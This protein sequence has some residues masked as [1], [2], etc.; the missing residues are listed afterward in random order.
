M[1]PVTDMWQIVLVFLV[2]MI[3]SAC[4]APVTPVGPPI[5]PNGPTYATGLVRDGKPK[6]GVMHW[7]PKHVFTAAANFS[8]ED[9]N[10]STP[11]RDQRSCGSCWA[12]GSTQMLEMGY[13][14]F[15]HKDVDFSEQD[16]VGNLFSGCGGGDFAGDFQVTKGQLGESDCPYQAS[17]HRCARL[18]PAVA[19]QGLR[20]GMVGQPDRSPTET[21]LQDAISTYGAIGAYVG[22]NNS[23]MNYSGGFETSCPSVST[24]HLITL[25]GWKTNPADGKI[26]FKIK[27]S[28]GTSWGENGYGYF[29]AGCYNLAE[30]AAWIEVQKAPCPPP[31]VKLPAEYVL[32]YGDD[33]VL[34]VKSIPG[35]TYG[36]YKDGVLLSSANILEM[37]AD[38]SLVLTLKVSNT[39]GNAT[40]QTL[41][42][43]KNVRD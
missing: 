6:Y 40:I 37:H 23:F 4:N 34:A 25:T 8:W 42:T 2:A 35:L 27:N 11:V 20:W 9:Q 15:G 31:G 43:V 28:W 39:C 3:L 22:A 17:N 36:W 33:V 18:P 14:I 26:Y 24:N 41:V 12:F 21:E 38:A 32:N 13:K 19:G 1:K 7:S 10:L 29:R 16:L 30:G 5:N